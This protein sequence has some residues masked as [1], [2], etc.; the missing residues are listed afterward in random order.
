MAAVSPPLGKAWESRRAHEDEMQQMR[1]RAEAERRLSDAE[2]AGRSVRNHLQEGE[3]IANR[4]P[5]K[6]LL[7]QVTPRLQRQSVPVELP[8]PPP[9]SLFS[10]HGGDGKD[11][12]GS[13]ALIDHL[14]NELDNKTREQDESLRKIQSL[15]G[16]IEEKETELQKIRKQQ[17]AAIKA[18]NLEVVKRLNEQCDWLKK[19][20]DS[21]EKEKDEAIEKRKA[22]EEEVDE[23]YRH[24]QQMRGVLRAQQQQQ[25][26]EPVPR[27]TPAVVENDPRPE[28][29]NSF[30]SQPR[31]N[32]QG[33]SE[34]SSRRNSRG[35]TTVRS[36]WECGSNNR[37][38]HEFVRHRSI[39]R[40]PA[41]L[42]NR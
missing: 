35:D 17:I 10:G 29:R 27:P 22:K 40:G 32:R 2:A 30:E 11:D 8:S 20:L 31:S 42:M 4:W 19:L 24:L 41:W 33:P 37:P 16:Q 36:T 12:W 38:K 7:P 14:Q 23:L 21:I 1:H 39:R 5:S 9:A 13:Q 6:D 28:S 3:P 15:K 26:E 25:R 18:D 34:T